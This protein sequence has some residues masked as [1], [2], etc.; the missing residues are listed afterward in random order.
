MPDGGSFTQGVLAHAAVGVLAA[1]LPMTGRHG[2]AYAR[3]VML[4]TA[5]DLGFLLVRTDYSDDQAWRAALSAAMAVYITDD[6]ERG[7]RGTA[8]SGVLGALESICRPEEAIAARLAN[9]S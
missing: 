3:A 8:A 5:P 1:T 6:F 2:H 7:G 9:R 4:P